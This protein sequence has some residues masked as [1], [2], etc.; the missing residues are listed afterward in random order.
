[1]LSPRSVAIL[2]CERITSLSFGAKLPA[3]ILNPLLD[4][5]AETA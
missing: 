4:T 1:M 3:K 5:L 2:W